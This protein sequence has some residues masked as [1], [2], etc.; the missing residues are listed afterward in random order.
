MRGPLGF[1]VGFD[2]LSNRLLTSLTSEISR[3]GTHVPRT[4]LR[5]VGSVLSKLERGISGVGR[6]NSQTVDVVHNVL[7]CSE[8]GRSR[9]VLARVRGLA[10]RCI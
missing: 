5:S 9:F 8:K 2:G 7:L 6:R 3:T 1:I 10:G 4:R